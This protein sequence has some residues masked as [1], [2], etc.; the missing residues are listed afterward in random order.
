[1]VVQL[2]VVVQKVLQVEFDVVVVIELFEKGS[3]I[4]L[5]QL[6][7]QQEMQGGL[8]LFIFVILF[9]YWIEAL[10]LG[11]D[12]VF[13]LLYDLVEVYVCL[14]V[15]VCCC[16]GLYQWEFWLDSLVVWLDEVIV[17]IGG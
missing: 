5:G 11:Y 14:K 12:D 10:E 4:C 2:K 1:M 3:V 15:I 8:L 16:I 17:W 9:V 6:F 7:W 13:F